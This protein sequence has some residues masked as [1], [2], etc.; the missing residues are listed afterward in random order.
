M[1]IQLKIKRKKF[2][3]G[4]NSPEKKEKKLDIN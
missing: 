1:A 2:V 4:I 3:L